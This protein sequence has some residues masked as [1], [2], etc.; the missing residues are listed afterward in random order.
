MVAIAAGD[1]IEVGRAYD[2]V[3]AQPRQN[4]IARPIRSVCPSAVAIDDPGNRGPI[5]SP[6]DQ[7]RQENSISARLLRA[8]TFDGENVNMFTA[9]V[10]IERRGTRSQIE[11]SFYY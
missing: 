11:R 2:N 3:V 10:P 9:P 5:D 4:G 1:R 8:K 7:H 6:A